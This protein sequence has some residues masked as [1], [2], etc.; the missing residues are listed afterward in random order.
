MLLCEHYISITIRAPPVVPGH[1]P[2]VTPRTQIAC[3]FYLPV[4]GT[5]SFLL[6]EVHSRAELSMW[7]A[8]DTTVMPGAQRERRGA[9]REG[10]VH[11]MMQSL[12]L[13]QEA[14]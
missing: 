3:F 9:N 2:G 8:L 13:V 11:Y 14:E 7:K 12:N 4:S 10:Q 1:L 5:W 6:S